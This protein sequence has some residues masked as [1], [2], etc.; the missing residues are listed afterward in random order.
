MNKIKASLTELNL[1][2]ESVEKLVNSTTETAFLAGTDY[3]CTALCERLYSAQKEI[4]RNLL[5]LKELEHDYL[6][7]QQE[8]VKNAKAPEDNEQDTEATNKEN[9]NTIFN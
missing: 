7:M 3:M 2:M 9:D 5:E 8:V 6:K 1:Y 4:N